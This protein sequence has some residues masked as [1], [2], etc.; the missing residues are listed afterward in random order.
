MTILPE[1]LHCYLISKPE[2]KERARSLITDYDI[3]DFRQFIPGVVEDGYDKRVTCDKF[4]RLFNRADC[5]IVDVE[6]KYGKWVS[7]H[8]M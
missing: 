6:L 3:S 8:I 2:E 1:E 4:W 5:G 7:I